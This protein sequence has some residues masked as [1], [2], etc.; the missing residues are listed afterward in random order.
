[1][2]RDDIRSPVQ[3]INLDSLALEFAAAPHDL[4]SQRTVIAAEFLVS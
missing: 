3:D 4:D 2:I 1:V